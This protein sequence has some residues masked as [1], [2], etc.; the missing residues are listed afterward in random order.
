MSWLAASEEQSDGHHES[1]HLA[2]LATHIPSPLHHT[3]DSPGH[4]FR[5]H[6][7]HA[8][9]SGDVVAVHAVIVHGEAH[10]VAPQ[11]SGTMLDILWEPEPNSHEARLKLVDAINHAFSVAKAY[12][13]TLSAVTEA[14]RSVKEDGR[15]RF[16]EQVMELAAPLFEIFEDVPPG[17]RRAKADAL[18][19][20]LRNAI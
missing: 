1:N 8:L 16:R 4:A 14:A 9:T 19:A 12:N 3:A 10:H 17:P 7:A 11:H 20:T 13:E 2:H 18:V 15:A 6:L 5:E